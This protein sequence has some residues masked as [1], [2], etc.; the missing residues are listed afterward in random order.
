[1]ITDHVYRP[2]IP[3]L[4]Q[5]SALRHRCAY[6]NCRRPRSEHERAVS[7]ARARR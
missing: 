1:M 5:A 4:T 2:M 7:G 6:L 3:T